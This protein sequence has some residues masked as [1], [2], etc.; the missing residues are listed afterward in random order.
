MLLTTTVSIFLILWTSI[1]LIDYYFR[2]HRI[3]FYINIANKI[4]LNV[5]LFSVKTF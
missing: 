5:D 3:N 1:Y 2:L 4:G